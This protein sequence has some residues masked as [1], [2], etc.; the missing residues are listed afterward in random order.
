MNRRGEAGAATKDK[1]GRTK[2][3]PG[4]SEAAHSVRRGRRVRLRPSSR[5]A[6]APPGEAP[7]SLPPHR[8]RRSRP[9]ERQRLRTSGERRGA[10]AA[11]VALEPL[12]QATI[13]GPQYH[14]GN[15]R[16]GEIVQQNGPGW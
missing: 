2:D 10:D 4:N 9:R 8:S 16:G 11:V 14:R 7:K 6:L 3:E 12:D 15:R 13:V 5:S 1:G